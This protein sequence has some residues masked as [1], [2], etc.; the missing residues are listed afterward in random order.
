[1][2][3]PKTIPPDLY[4]RAAWIIN[5]LHFVFS[6]TL[7]S[8]SSSRRKSSLGDSC[9]ICS[10]GLHKQHSRDHVAW[11]FMDE[12]RELVDPM[13]P[14]D[15]PD[16]GCAYRGDKIDSVCRHL[17]LFHSKLDEFLSDPDLVA[18]KKLEVASKPQKVGMKPIN[19]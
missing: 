6:P 1:M 7:P 16:P 10:Q 9:P 14:L 18:E 13:D 8:N 3:G 19:S 12:L 4:V 11:H 2:S 15:C 5:G 17:A